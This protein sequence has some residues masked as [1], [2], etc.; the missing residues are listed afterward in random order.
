MGAVITPTLDKKCVKL[1]GDQMSN[2]T[3]VELAFL[4]KHNVQLDQVFDAYGLT[5]IEYRKTMREQGKIVAF[6]VAPCK[7]NGHTLRTRSGHCIQCKPARLEYQKRNELAGIVYIAGTIQGKM[8]KVGFSDSIEKREESLNRTKYAS[9][10]DWKILAAIRSNFAGQI[11]NEI[12]PIL[13]QHSY[14]ANYNH[15][16][17][18]HE[19]SETYFCAYSKIRLSLHQ[20]IKTRDY[21]FEIV[22]NLLTDNY[23]FLD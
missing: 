20:L 13:K 6:N 5:K 1:K 23:E 8:I 4:K 9:C 12:R 19:T 22:L 21:D 16:G 3:D 17:K 7:E 15:D 14:I 10:D 11:E 18:Q 2:L